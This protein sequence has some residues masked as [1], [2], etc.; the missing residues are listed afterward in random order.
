MKRYQRRPENENLPVRRGLN[1]DYRSREYL[2]LDEVTRLIE[3]AQGRGRHRVRDSA[4]LLIMFRHGLRATEAAKMRWDAV[5]LAERRVVI[6]RLKGSEPG[7][8]PLQADEVAALV[9]LRAAYPDS[10]YLFPNERGGPITR[11]AIARI[12]ERCGELAEL[13][14]PAHAHMLR[15]ACGYHLANQG[16]DTRLIQEWLGHRSIE[17]TVRYTRLNPARFEQISWV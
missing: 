14:L 1:S 13:P 15:H 2:T 3:V 4:L 5:M 7:N 12:V 10:P 16:L 9:A 11:A 17:H 6:H 8:H